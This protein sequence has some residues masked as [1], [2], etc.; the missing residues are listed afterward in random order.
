MFPVKKRRELNGSKGCLVVLCLLFVSLLSAVRVWA[1]SNS[2][3][4]KLLGQNTLRPPSDLRATT[5]SKEMIELVW[6]DNSEDEDGFRI[7]CNNTLIGSVGRNVTTFQH[8]GLEPG[9]LHR[10]EVRAFNSNGE[11]EP[12][13]LLETPPYEEH[14]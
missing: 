7:Y 9:K 1:D 5:V 10:Y 8:R 4:K 3:Q 6:R 13:S 2:S 14:Y 12:A 11:S